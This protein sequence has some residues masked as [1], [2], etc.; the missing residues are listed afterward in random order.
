MKGKEVERILVEVKDSYCPV[1]IVDEHLKNPILLSHVSN[2]CLI[3]L[4]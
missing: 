4:I 3:H 2:I 1:T